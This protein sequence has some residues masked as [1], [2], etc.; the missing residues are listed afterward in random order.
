MKKHSC[1]TV[2]F[3]A[4]V[5]AGCGGNGA[6]S[7]ECLLD[8]DC[9]GG[10]V[11][12]AGLCVD[13]SNCGNGRLDP[14]ETCDG[15][16]PVTCNDGD[17]CT[18]DVLNGSAADCTAACVY[19]PLTACNDGDGC[20][21]DG[22][23]ANDD[24][25]CIQSDLSI[26]F[27][28]PTDEDAARVDR[29]WT[30]IAVRV[31][32]GLPAAACLDFAGS[33]AGYW[34]FDTGDGSQVADESRHTNNGVRENGAELAAGKFGQALRLDGQDDRLVIPFA[35]SL[36]LAASFTIEAWLRPAVSQEV[37]AGADTPGNA[38]I[39]A[40]ADGD[41][42]DWSWQLRYGSPDACRLGFHLNTASGGVWLSTGQSLESGRW[43]HLAVTGDGS[44]VAL[45]LDGEKKDSAP[46]AGVKSSSKHL[47]LGEDG[48]GNF[49][50][51]SIDEFRI[52]SRALSAAEIQAAREAAGRTFS[53]RFSGLAN[54][55]YEYYALARDSSGASVRTET[56][57]VVIASS[58][59]CDGV[60]CSGHGECVVT[61][62]QASCDCEEGYHAVGLDCEED[63]TT[64]GVSTTPLRPGD[65][66]PVIM[67]MLNMR[68][69]TSMATYKQ[70]IDL[71]KKE[72]DEYKGECAQSRHGVEGCERV[73][74][75]GHPAAEEGTHS[76]PDH[77]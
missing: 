68:G 19:L 6:N 70:V 61:D 38:G 63:Q 44:E 23:T 13:A 45:F 57:Q 48:W 46:A 34:S 17:P 75:V 22:C 49:F 59:P 8:S 15:D 5:L 11:C 10:L 32:S 74:G 56:R 54:G 66:L 42:Q 43:Y 16:C 7:P 67:F 65:R 76:E 58:D 30:E 12:R 27:V 53:R 39:A 26:E 50:Q 51:G 1:W 31:S 69:T 41:Q 4:L 25:D 37:C 60:T 36:Q 55:T 77:E 40:Q 72:Y 64:S 62:G 33:L 28:A 21:P 52:H 71:W 20:C 3:M 14:G 2:V 35:S 73:V 24:D 47:V 29:N 18:E 9:L